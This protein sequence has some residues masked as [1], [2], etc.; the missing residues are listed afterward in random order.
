MLLTGVFEI[1]AGGMLALGFLTPVA[2]LLIAAHSL[3]VRLHLLP[4][5]SPPEFDS[6]MG[7][8]FGMAILL[9]LIVQG[10]GA[11]SIDGRLFGRREIII[12]RPLPRFPS[13]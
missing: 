11:Y 7:F 9:A 3:S 5:L 6:R 4:D 10:A 1:A 12:P 8:L 13:S 2:G